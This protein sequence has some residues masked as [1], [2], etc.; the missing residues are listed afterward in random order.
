DDRSHA[1]ERDAYAEPRPARH[2]IPGARPERVRYAQ[3]VVLRRAAEA[4][5]DL[6]VSRGLRLG[7]RRFQASARGALGLCDRVWWTRHELRWSAAPA[8]SA[9]RAVVTSSC[10]VGAQS[11]PE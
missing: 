9:A 8:R 11:G 1:R 7:S 10:A 3:V 6:P 2:T 4:G 5:A